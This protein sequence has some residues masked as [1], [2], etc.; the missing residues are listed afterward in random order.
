M[1]NTLP[2]KLAVPVDSTWRWGTRVQLYTNNGSGAVDCDQPLL[3]RPHDVFARSI[4]PKG[5]AAVPH[6]V[7]A[8]ATLQPEPPHGGGHAM[9]P[10]ASVPHAAGEAYAEVT[11]KVAEG[12]GVYTFG[13]KAVV[14]GNVQAGD[15]VEFDHLVSGENPPP[16]KITYKEYDSETD[17]VS[18]DLAV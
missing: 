6:A 3:T 15:P 4:E 1:P 11:V 9:T 18:F 2:V 12:F 17:Q 16:V 8:H 10:H 13:A 14:A 7:T 5:H